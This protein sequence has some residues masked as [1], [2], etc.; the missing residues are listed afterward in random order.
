MIQRRAV[1]KWRNEMH[2][3]QAALDLEPGVRAKATN[4]D[5]KDWAKAAVDAVPL[6]TP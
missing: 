1:E 3:S 4:H 5:D 6:S 2:R